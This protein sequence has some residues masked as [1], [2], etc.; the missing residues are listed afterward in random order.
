MERESKNSKLTRSATIPETQ[1][2]LD[3]PSPYYP[4][5]G[6]TTEASKGATGFEDFPEGGTRAWASVVGSVS[7][8]IVFVSQGAISAFGV[9]QDFYTLIIRTPR[10][11]MLSLAQPHNYYQ[12]FLS[13]G[14][15]VGLGMGL[16]YI[17]SITLNFHY[18]KRRR[19]VAVGIASTGSAI[20]AICQ[21]IG[22]NHLI[23]GKV[24]FP[25]GVRIFGFIFLVL[26]IIGNVLMRPR[27]PPR[28]LRPNQPKPDVK[29][30]VRDIPLLLSIVG[31]ALL[32]FGVYFPSI[33]LSSF[34][35]G[36]ISFVMIKATNQS[37]L[38]AFTILYG[39]IAGGYFSLASS[40]ISAYVD[41][42]HEVGFALG[43]AAFIQ[44]FFVL[45]AQPVA[46]AIVDAPR[47][48]WN[49]AIVAVS[50]GHYLWWLC[51][52]PGISHDVGET[53]EDVEG[54]TPSMPPHK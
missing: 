44:S 47:Y 27:L 23:N 16:V 25:W 6:N 30:I 50:V 49:R 37:G 33:L 48:R 51:Y 11:F 28:R 18:F 45:I 5:I 54:L 15:G 19:G 39:F 4:P 14:V 1:S 24:G 20:G 9:Y 52:H 42:T 40:A 10:F 13:Q 46:G 2:L 31:T 3:I 41:N 7:F 26:V 22:L 36:I 35:L 32:L 53:E 34:L 21:T 43:Y 38:I 8:C 29:K 17:P 12:V